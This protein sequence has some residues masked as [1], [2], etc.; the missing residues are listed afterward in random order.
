MNAIVRQQCGFSFTGFILVAAILIS[1]AIFG[2]KIIPSYMEN[3]K[4]QKAMDAIVHDPALQTATVAEIKD[5]FAK[6]AVTMDN[7]TSITENDL[8]IGK[9]EGRL[10]LSAS[11]SVKVPLAGNVSLLIEFN[12]S[13]SQ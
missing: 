13:A 1:A 11:Y 4:I 8:V 7:V 3:G 10:S 12:P 2:M 6:R 9:A 5:T